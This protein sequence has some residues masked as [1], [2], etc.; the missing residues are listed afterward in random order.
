MNEAY[1][2]PIRAPLLP[3]K[4]MLENRVYAYGQDFLMLKPSVRETHP[5]SPQNQQWEERALP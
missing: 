2:R 3:I 1:R 4:P 5:G